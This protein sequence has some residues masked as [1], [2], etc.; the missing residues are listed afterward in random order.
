MC[1]GGSGSLQHAPKRQRAPPSSLIACWPAPFVACSS[2]FTVPPRRSSQ[3]RS[4]LD[5]STGYLRSGSRRWTLGC[6]ARYTCFGFRERG[7]LV[8]HDPVGPSG[9]LVVSPLVGAS[10]DLDRLGFS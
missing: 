10:R 3:P 5:H 4:S 6:C 9:T 7:S 2:H 8:D 1:P